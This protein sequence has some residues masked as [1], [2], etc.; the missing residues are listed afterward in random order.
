V[1][2]VIGDPPF[3]GA[4]QLIVTLTFVLVD[5]AGAAGT[6]GF[7]AALITTSD[8]SAPKPTRLRA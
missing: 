5:V 8:E 1:Y 6:P 2:D 4:V 7:A 3:D